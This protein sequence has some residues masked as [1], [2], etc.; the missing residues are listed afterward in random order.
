MPVSRRRWSALR[1]QILS[2]RITS[3]DNITKLSEVLISYNYPKM[4]ESSMSSP[5]TFQAARPIR[6]RSGG[7]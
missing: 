7:T 1:P 6:F 4:V 2:R 5:P 3:K